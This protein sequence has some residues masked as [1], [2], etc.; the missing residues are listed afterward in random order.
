[1]AGISNDLA[2]SLHVH[3]QFQH[4]GGTYVDGILRFSYSSLQQY[5]AGVVQ[6]LFL[7]S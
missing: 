5:P 1:M 7:V 4:P 6:E 2:T 3:L